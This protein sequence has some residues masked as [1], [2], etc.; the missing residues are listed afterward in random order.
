MTIPADFVGALDPKAQSELRELLKAEL[1]VRETGLG[2]RTDILKKQKDEA[3]GKSQNLNHGRMDLSAATAS[4]KS[5]EADHDAAKKTANE[6]RKVND[7]A[8][9][10]VE[11]T[12]AAA[13]SA[14]DGIKTEID[15]DQKSAASKREMLKQEKDAAGNA[16]K[17]AD[18]KSVTAKS[19]Q[20]E[21]STTLT[22]LNK[23]LTAA[24]DVVKVAEQ[25]V[26]RLE[27]VA[28]GLKSAF[29]DLADAVGAFL[30]GK[31]DKA[32]EKWNKAKKDL[33]NAR[34]ALA[35][36]NGLLKLAQD[37][38]NAGDAALKKAGKELEKAGKVVADAGKRLET[39]AKNFNAQEQ[40]CALRDKTVR[41]MSKTPAEWV[42]FIEEAGT[43]GE[44][45]L[46][47]LVREYHKAVD[48][49]SMAVAKLSEAKAV[50][51]DTL[52]KVEE[53]QIVQVVKQEAVKAREQVVEESQNVVK[54][55]EKAA[56]DAAA[57]VKDAVA[58]LTDQEIIPYQIDSTLQ[59]S[60]NTYSGAMHGKLD[61]DFAGASLDSDQVKDL[62]RGNVSLPAFNPIQLAAACFATKL[63]IKDEGYSA[64]RSKA[65][66]TDAGGVE[67]PTT[68]SVSYF[69]SKRFVD[70]AEGGTIARLIATS[71]VDGGETAK[72][73]IKRQLLL[74]FQDITTWAKLQGQNLSDD[75]AA[76]LL[77]SILEDRT[78]SIPT[79]TFDARTIHYDF[80]V[81][82][83]G[84]SMLPKPL[85]ERA[86]SLFRPVTDRLNAAT[87]RREAAILTDHGGFV[88]T[89]GNLPQQ[90]LE[91]RAARFDEF[92]MQGDQAMRDGATKAFR[93][94]AA[95]I[96]DAKVRQIVTELVSTLERGG[97]SDV[98]LLRSLSS[99]VSFKSKDLQKAYVPGRRIIN[100]LPTEFGKK[101][102]SV[103]TRCAMGNKGGATLESFE[104]DLATYTLYGKA[105]IRHSHSWGKLKD[106]L[107][108]F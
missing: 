61:L 72:S 7:D 13:I 3:S 80:A 73:E 22:A 83:Y 23:K 25:E 62:L 60:V 6:R 88:I 56:N 77:L 19:V 94:L 99:L 2:V 45:A 102:E 9:V 76:E 39:A 66:T 79:L 41:D 10:N 52:H 17:D 32:E 27:G 86:E 74:E 36:K 103:F 108:T 26:A 70:W 63:S 78:P 34:D 40:L 69:A 87:K 33:S 51:A 4:V 29:D 55:V 53:S 54:T 106:I 11:K 31:R 90:S 20:D 43:H 101:A 42:K 28:D 98:D 100:L 107:G 59:F 91:D 16:K 24:K 92:F 89:I 82:T 104:F 68:D 81:E 37:A 67:R 84:T 64:S 48:E 47:P 71:I 18:T 15:A 1:S 14:F 35:E 96:K 93:L 8:A 38:Y 65:Y 95:K 21:A 12:S 50:V 97:G 49:A 30:Q 5:N 75:I 105:R 44:K 57:A 85:R 46:L 58:L